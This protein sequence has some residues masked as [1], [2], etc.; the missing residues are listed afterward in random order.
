[1]TR[2]VVKIG[3]S[4][5]RRPA[6]LQ[7]VV[8]IVRSYPEPPVL[9]VSAFAGITDALLHAAVE[10]SS[11]GP[12]L[13]RL[14]RRIHDFLHWR[15]RPLRSPGVRRQLETRL[16][17]AERL[18]SRRGSGETAG[19]WREVVLS[20]G[21]KVASLVVC[22][23]LN[24][25]GINCREVWPEEIGLMVAPGGRRAAIDLEASRARVRSSL[26]GPGVVVVPGFYG[27]TSTGAVRLL[28]RNGSDYSA[29]AIAACLDAGWLDLCKDVEGI[30]SADPA[31]VASTAPVSR[32]SYAEAEAVAGF[33]NGVLHGETIRPVARAGIPVRLFGIGADAP[34]R[35]PTVVASRPEG[36]T[37]GAKTVVSRAA[38]DFIELAWRD[39]VNH[40]QITARALTGLA[41]E[42]LSILAQ[43][44]TST[45]LQLLLD[46]AEAGP[47][48]DLLRSLPKAEVTVRAARRC[49]LV[50]LVGEP[51]DG[52]ASPE[53]LLGGLRRA[54]VATETV[55]LGRSRAAAYALVPE[56]CRRTAVR[57][58]HEAFL[59][60]TETGGLGRPIT[61][62]VVSRRAVSDRRQPLRATTSQP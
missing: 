43:A 61:K 10:P 29:A 48:L 25:A 57:A 46:R 23:Q 60:I 33:G 1:M 41:S 32:L 31:D 7:R 3:G 15:G 40:S 13:S 34:D 56:G 16:A 36:W 12:E 8:R 51:T 44:S 28:G 5:L 22:A 17:V 35:P 50:A 37:T 55:I 19:G 30:R 39:S 58:W 42:Q 11:E 9:V 38:V 18:M 21:E 59:P 20:Y 6:D 24:R 26:G 62:K 14:R 52:Q 27:V 54:G 45:G 47:A 2:S 49:S 4:I 53:K